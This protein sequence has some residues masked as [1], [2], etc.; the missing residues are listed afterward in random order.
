MRLYPL[1]LNI[2][3]YRCI[4]VGGGVI[5]E[6]KVTALVECG[7]LVT[8][9]SP[10]VSSL[11]QELADKDRIQLY[12]RPFSDD[13]VSGARIVI[14]ATDNRE[15]NFRVARAAKANGV[16]VNVVDQPDLCDF[17]VPAVLRR[18]NLTISVSTGGDSPVLAAALRRKLEA[19][20]GPEYAIFLEWLSEFRARLKC[21]VSSR[22]ARA[23]AE[24]NLV[25]SAVLSLLQD[26]K[27]EEARAVLV[28]L[29]QDAINTAANKD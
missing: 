29:L 18:G 2:E 3:G 23:S 13:D 28:A 24:R 26:G 20:F 7:A 27:R 21:S 6:R 17:H 4:V 8:V 11:V 16:L 1:A 25:D 15:T 19:Q 12:R 10:E 14:A 22:T 9:I 5:A